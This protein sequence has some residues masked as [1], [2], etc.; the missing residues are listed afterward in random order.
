MGKT[1]ISLCILVAVNAMAAISA[2]ANIRAPEKHPGSCVAIFNESTLTVTVRVRTPKGY[3][4]TVWKIGRADI[5]ANS[6]GV[7]LTTSRGPIV[8]SNGDWDLTIDPANLSKSWQYLSVNAKGCNGM[9]SISVGV[10][11]G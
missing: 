1:T 4:G 9:W 7:T 10:P 6:M 11:A 8:S 5:M 2:S 3:S